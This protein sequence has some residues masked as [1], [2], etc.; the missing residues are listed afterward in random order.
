MMRDFEKQRRSLFAIAAIWFSFIAI[1]SLGG[2]AALV[3]LVYYIITSPAVQN[4]LGYN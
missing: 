2:V 1:L 4:L 3:W